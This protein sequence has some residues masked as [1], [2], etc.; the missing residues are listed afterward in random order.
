VKHAL[1]TGITGQD[2]SYLAELLLEK[3]YE[4][5]GTLRRTSSF[6]TGRIDHIFDRLHLHHAD[7]LDATS[8]RRVVD[9][10]RPDEVYHLAAQSHVRVSFD[11][12]EYTFEVNATGTLRLLEAVRSVAPK[13]RFYQAGSSEMFGNAPAPQTIDTPFHPR[14]PY[15]V[16]KVAAHWHAVNYREAYG[17]FVSN[18]ILFNHESP[19]RG[20]TFV[21]QKIC[22]AV[23]RRDPV[24][25]LGNLDARRDWGWAP[26]YVRAM[27]M[28]LQRSGPGDFVVATGSSRRVSD[29]FARACAVGG[30][31][32]VM[33]TGAR[34]TRPSEVDHL[35][36]I[37]NLPGWSPTHDF[38]AI[39]ERMVLA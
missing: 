19:R 13:A 31:T 33:S 30:H 7:M 9:L 27:W 18:G 2:G 37:S 22:Q 16:S 24:I 3:G 26:D 10:T 32:P 11:E 17:M 14:S 15:G 28:M 38:G 34:L 20:P 6:N 5:H 23:K 39:V 21:T 4:V 1:I 29:W 8:I 12:P 25:E 36:G 35:C